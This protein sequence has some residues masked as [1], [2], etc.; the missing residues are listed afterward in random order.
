MYHFILTQ[1]APDV[2][3]QP[4]QIA[5]V[6]AAL[7]CASVSSHDSNADASVEL[8]GTPVNTPPAVVAIQAVPAVAAPSQVTVAGFDRF[9]QLRDKAARLSSAKV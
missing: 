7:M 9:L 3:A 8:Y 5:P 4:H 6:T 1:F 2:T